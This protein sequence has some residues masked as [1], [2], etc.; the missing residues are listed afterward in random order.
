MDS[1]LP[2]KQALIALVT[3]PLLRLALKTCQERIRSRIQGG[4]PNLKKQG[5]AFRATSTLLM[6]KGK[7]NRESQ[8]RERK[9]K[10]NPTT[11][12]YFV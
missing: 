9:K 2:A 11:C 8:P 10:P 3:F 12:I 7:L 6:E 1:P 5:D 4:L